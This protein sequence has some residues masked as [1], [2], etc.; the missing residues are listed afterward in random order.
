M[1]KQYQE[2]K[3]EVIELTNEDI[4]VTSQYDPQGLF[5]DNNKFNW[6]WS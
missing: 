1:K 4:I 5:D 6:D 3:L 2:P